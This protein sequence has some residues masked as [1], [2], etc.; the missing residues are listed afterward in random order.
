MF[1]LKNHR[2]LA[3]S[4]AV[5][6]TL[7][8]VL[9]GCGSKTDAPKAGSDKL[10]NTVL[11]VGATP[12]PHAEILE[13]IKPALL[14]EG[15]D[16]QIVNY[17]DYVRPNLDLDTGDID[18]NFFQ[19]TPYLDSFNQDHSLKNVS[20]ANVHIE[21]MGIYS[22]KITKLDDLKNGDTIAIPNDPS[23]AGR[24]LALLAK[25]GL[26]QLKNGTGIKGT[27]NDIQYNPKQLKIPPL[28]APQLPRVLQDPKVVAAVINTNYALEGG[29]NPL[30]DS[31]IME[32]KESPYANILVVKESKKDDPAL[33]KLAK[34]LTSPD[35]KKF[36]EDKYKGSIVPAF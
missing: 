23:N 13:H 28:D 1:K 27:V 10:S 18:A 19:H 31:I 32:D 6:V 2:Y 3:L 35:V 25:A 7:S 8:L 15:V 24:A 34:A 20:I 9:S 36:I 12:I 33:Q 4:L 11:K 21:P 5:L 26:I 14:K 22:K 16:L 29:L 17:T 30:N